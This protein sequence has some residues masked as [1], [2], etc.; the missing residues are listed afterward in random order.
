METQAETVIK[1]STISRRIIKSKSKEELKKIEFMSKQYEE[2]LKNKTPENLL[3][4]SAIIES[5]I[6]SIR[7]LKIKYYFIITIFF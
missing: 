2:Y 3:K 7:V 5:N 4:Y 1:L 6:I